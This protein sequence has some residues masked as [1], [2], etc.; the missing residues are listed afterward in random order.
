M[1]GTLVTRHRRLRGQIM[2]WLAVML[3]IVV[4][5]LLFAISYGTITLRAMRVM[6]AAD[7]AAHAGAQAVRLWPNGRLRDG[8]QAEET[9][10]RF[11]RAQAPSYARLQGVQC[12]VMDAGPYCEVTAHVPGG[13]FLAPDRVVQ[14]RAVLAYG[15]TREKQ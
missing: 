7:L 6:A 12:G 3:P 8:R 9:A 14:A 5:L 10:A 1:E 2:P 13:F 4:L 11:F 15:T